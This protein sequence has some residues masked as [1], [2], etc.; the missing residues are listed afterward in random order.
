M[1]YTIIIFAY[2]FVGTVMAVAM[3]IDEKPSI[4]PLL[5][6]PIILVLLFI[7]GLF[8][9]AAILGEKIREILN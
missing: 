8:N 2:L 6:W 1:I 5:F 9:I 3:A 4:L 7:F